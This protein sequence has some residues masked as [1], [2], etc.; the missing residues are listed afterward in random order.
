MIY[1]YICSS[2][3]LYTYTYIHNLYTYVY[4]S[5]HIYRE[6]QAYASQIADA[7]GIPSN[8]A[9]KVLLGMFWMGSNGMSSLKY[10][11]LMSQQSSASYPRTE[12]S[13]LL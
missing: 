2:V 3:G 7:R 10:G 12:A 8:C 11:V 13:S 4:I 6:V 5:T 9:S 1:M